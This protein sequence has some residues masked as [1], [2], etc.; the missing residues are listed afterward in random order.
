M[1]R[2]EVRNVAESVGRR[3]AETRPSLSPPLQDSPP[4]PPRPP[5]GLPHVPTPQTAFLVSL[6]TR[7]R[8]VL[9]PFCLQIPL[10]PPP[11]FLTSTFSLSARPGYVFPSIH[12]SPVLSF[13]IYTF[14]PQNTAGD[15]GFKGQKL[16]QRASAQGRPCRG[17]RARDHEAPVVL[18]GGPA[19]GRGPASPRPRP[20]RERVPALLQT[21]SRFLL[22]LFFLPP[23]FY[24]C[25]PCLLFSKMAA[26]RPVSTWSPG[27]SSSGCS[28]KLAPGFS[29]KYP[30]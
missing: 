26:P 13:L 23:T 19:L 20:Q 27:D 8:F 10:F 7:P 29:S 14:P 21:L 25:C 18:T 6:E 17:V 3:S 11:S 12:P 30:T 9:T 2:S 22:S 1:R 15:F 4:E 5:D 24:N 28:G 16:H